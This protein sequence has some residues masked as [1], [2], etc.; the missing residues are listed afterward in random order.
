[1][2]PIVDQHR[3]MLRYITKYCTEYMTAKEKAASRHYFA[4]VKLFKYKDRS[5]S[6]SDAY[7]N[8]ASDDPEV[9]DLLKDG[10]DKFE[11]IYAQR[12]YDEHLDKLDINRCPSCSGVARTPEAKQ[13]RYCGHSWRDK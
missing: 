2:K 8:M 6:A 4:Q 10:Y 7:Y 9:L 5:P 12:I 11:E 1:M 3:D 13:C